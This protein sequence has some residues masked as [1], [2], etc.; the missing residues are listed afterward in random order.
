MTK[1]HIERIA[2]R[3]IDMLDARFMAG[4]IT[5]AQYDAEMRQI[6]QW[7]DSESRFAR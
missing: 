7:A 5:Q 3:L 6:S 2:E 1:D 4:K